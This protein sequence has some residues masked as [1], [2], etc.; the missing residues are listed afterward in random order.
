MPCLAFRVWPSRGLLLVLAHYPSSPITTCPYPVKAPGLVIWPF[1]SYISKRWALGSQ[2][3]VVHEIL[4]RNLSGYAMSLINYRSGQRSGCTLM[5]RNKSANGITLLSL[6]VAFDWLSSVPHL[7]PMTAP[8]AIKAFINLLCTRVSILKRPRCC[9]SAVSRT[10]AVTFSWAEVYACVLFF[11]ISAPHHR[12]LPFSCCPVLRKPHMLELSEQV[13]IG[14]RRGFQ[15]D[16][17]WHT[18][19]Y[20]HTHSHSSQLMLASC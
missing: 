1:C 3:V 5:C 6:A 10:L 18:D 12:P 15:Y 2:I 19:T 8:G 14:W 9:S 20:S 17:W 7:K 4:S 13:A 16:L 11:S